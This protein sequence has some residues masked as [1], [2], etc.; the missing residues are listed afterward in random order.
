MPQEID[1]ANLDLAS[2]IR[3]G[4]H[5][6]WGQGPGEAQTLVEK[7]VEQ[8]H[9]IGSISAFVGGISYSGNLKP[10]HADQIKFTAYGAIGE[11][12]KLAQAGVLRLI[13]CHLSHLMSYLYSGTIESD[14]VL[15]QVS[16][17][18]S[19]GEY[20]YGAAVDYMPAAIAKARVVIA[21]VNDQAPWTWS[22]CSLPRE[23]IDYIVRVS[24]PP[25]MVEGRVIGAVEEGIARHICNY[26]ED[27]TTIQIGIGG[28]PDA[29]M[30][31]VGDRR[32]LGFHSGL[33]NDRVADLMERGVITNARKPID[34]GL[35]IAAGLLGTRRLFDF[36]DHNRAIRLMSFDYTHKAGILARQG[37]IIAINS[38]VE[39]DLTGQVNAEVASGQYIGAVGGQ[40]DFVRGVQLSPEGRSVI[41]LPSTARNDQVSR[42]VARL[43]GPVTTAR[44]D[45]D[46]IATEFG[47]AELRGQPLDERVRRM[48]AI[49]HPAFRESLERESRSA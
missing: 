22:D 31:A 5:V 48:I 4:D 3:A 13:P 23:R 42:I 20:S 32:D 27:G 30:A 33:I 44:S 16:P 7:L 8:R 24:R 45:A 46:L 41:A 9:R 43:N 15:V 26:I 1:A 34:P 49:A 25:L 6:V 19:S 39:V 36:A 10:E 47:I 40:G 21:E 17:P 37:K 38:A 35:A 11:L 29:I 14:V 2:I 18:D 12:R 28:I